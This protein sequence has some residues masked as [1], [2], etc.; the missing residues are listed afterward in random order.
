MTTTMTSSSPIAS[1]ANALIKTRGFYVEIRT[2]S[3]NTVNEW[4]RRAGSLT[5][6]SL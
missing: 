4:N 5:P 6:P 2:N 3:V 1:I